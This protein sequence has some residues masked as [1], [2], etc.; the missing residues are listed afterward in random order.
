[1]LMYLA[2]RIGAHSPIKI[3]NER[4]GKGW[5]DGR[6]SFAPLSQADLAQIRLEL[7]THPP[8]EI[9][10]EALSEFFSDLQDQL[11]TL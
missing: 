9:P 10:P 5:L 6:G 3:K 11:P 8:K 2:V 4:W 7:E 1:M